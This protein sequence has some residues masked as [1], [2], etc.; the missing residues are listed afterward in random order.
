MINH[1]KRGRHFGYPPCCI[2]WFIAN[3]AGDDITELNADQEQAH[4][5]TG[6][7]PCPTCAKHVTRET[8]QNL[9]TNRTC[10]SRFPHGTDKNIHVFYRLMQAGRYSPKRMIANLYEYYNTPNPFETTT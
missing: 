2:E 6:F 4:G 1:I 3:R 10:R 7:I 8:L 9:L 5:G